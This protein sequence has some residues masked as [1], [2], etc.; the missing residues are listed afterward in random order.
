MGKT[1]QKPEARSDRPTH[2]N[3]TGGVEW[4]KSKKI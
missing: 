4:A 3:F 1:F 2:L